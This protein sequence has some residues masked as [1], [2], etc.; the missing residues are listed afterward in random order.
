MAGGVFKSIN[1]GASW[2]PMNAGLTNLF[3]YAL[4]LDPLTFTT[5]YAGTGGGMFA[6]EAQ[7]PVGIPTLPQWGMLLFT[8][9]EKMERRDGSL[10][11][12]HRPGRSHRLLEYRQTKNNKQTDQAKNDPDK[13]SVQLRAENAALRCVSRGHG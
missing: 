6:F 11:Q 1:G 8:L 9:T 5:L 7:E 4:S 10:S 2:T 13:K 12:E 3:V